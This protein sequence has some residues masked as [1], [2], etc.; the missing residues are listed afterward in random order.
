MKKVAEGSERT[1]SV[2]LKAP[3][4]FKPV[5][6]YMATVKGKIFATS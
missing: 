1:V 5:P 2:T 6:T 4:S 3:V